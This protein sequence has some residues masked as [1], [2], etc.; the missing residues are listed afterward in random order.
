MTPKGL[1]SKRGQRSRIGATPREAAV[2]DWFKHPT[3]LPADPAI[4]PTDAWWTA[5]DVMDQTGL[6]E[7]RRQCLAELHRLRDRGVLL[8]T[9]RRWRYRPASWTS[10]MFT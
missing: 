6:Y 10:V 1:D 4:I 9:G 3:G 8:T 7:S 5:Q 2:I